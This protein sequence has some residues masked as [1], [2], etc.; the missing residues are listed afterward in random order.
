MRPPRGRKASPGRR[1]PRPQV[2]HLTNK[3]LVKIENLERFTGLKCLYLEG[4]AFDTIEGLDALPQLMS[5]YL[6]K[7]A[8][9]GISAGLSHLSQ[10]VTLDLSYNLIRR[11]ENLACLPRLESLLVTGNALTDA[12]SVVELRGCPALS[13]LD[14]ADNRIDDEAALEIVES[15]PLK[16]LRM[17]GNPVVSSVGHYRKRLLSRMP[18]LAFLDDGPAFEK[19]VRLAKAFFEGGFEAERAERDALRQEAQDE[20][21]RQRRAF[22]DFLAE[23]RRRNAENPRPPA[24]P[25]RFRAVPPGESDGEDDSDLPESCRAP[26][27]APAAPP[28]GEPGAGGGGAEGDAGGGERGGGRAV[29]G[30]GLTAAERENIESTL[31]A[32]IAMAG[33]I[34]ELARGAAPAAAPP[35]APAPGA[36]ADGGAP[37]MPD[38]P[39]LSAEELE[40]LRQMKAEAFESEMAHR[41]EL[42]EQVLARAAARAEAT[43]QRF[44][45]QMSGAP[46]GPRGEGG[47]PVSPSGYRRPVVYGTRQYRQLWEM[48]KDVPEV[49]DPD[50]EPGA[51][52]P[53]GLGDEASQVVAAGGGGGGGAAAGAPAPD[54]PA[55]GGVNAEDS[56]RSVPVSGMEDAGGDDLDGL[57]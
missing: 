10:L 3:G 46:A 8:L 37:E 23:A 57:D 1:R 18:T 14:L 45:A 44:A 39:E 21:E 2:I 13:S 56:V 15:L 31:A 19:D 47:G 34:G 25:M 35:A 26:R 22:N 48:A 27:A 50:D 12:S 41:R 32:Q 36:A 29:T 33:Q 49:A 51:G 4:N 9:T 53:G 55:A 11:L 20:R 6:A 43:S 40:S 17:A 42:R 7:N 5:L 28:D 30:G 54:R 16:Y 38:M 24:D 52:A